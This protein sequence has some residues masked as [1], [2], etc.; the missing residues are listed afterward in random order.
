[1]AVPS[2]SKLILKSLLCS[3]ADASQ[4]GDLRLTI[5]TPGYRIEVRNETQDTGQG[6]VA[7]GFIDGMLF[8][9][10]ALI[11][12]RARDEFEVTDPLGQSSFTLSQAPRAAS[13][14][15]ACKNG[16]VLKSTD[17]TVAGKAVSVA[18]VLGDWFLFSY[19]Y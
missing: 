14:F 18:G 12:R 3:Y 4:D 17:Y 10:G 19:W 15:T 13:L 8:A 7:P 2:D 16:L 5:G 11:D 9:I 1:M 6:Y